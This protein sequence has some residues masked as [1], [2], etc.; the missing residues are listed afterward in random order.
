[1][2]AWPKGRPA[3]LENERL[4]SRCERCELYK[5]SP[6]LNAAEREQGIWRAAA[7][8]AFVLLLLMTWGCG[9]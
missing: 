6:A 8:A 2:N 7:V 4:A 1:M 9:R 5:L 3:V